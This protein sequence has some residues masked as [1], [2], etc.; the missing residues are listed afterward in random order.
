[1][2]SYSCINQFSHLK[3]VIS[4]KIFLVNSIFSLLT[5]DFYMQYSVLRTEI[6]HSSTTPPK[7]YHPSYSG[8]IDTKL[9]DTL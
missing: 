6:L 3:K 5:V 4:R 8:K 9:P 2:H 7:T 1:M